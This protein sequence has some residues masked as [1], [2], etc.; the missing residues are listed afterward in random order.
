MS[1]ASHWCCG[2]QKILEQ[3]QTFSASPTI[4]LSGTCI[5]RKAINKDKPLSSGVLPSRQR[6]AICSIL[7]YTYSIRGLPHVRQNGL[8]LFIALARMVTFCKE[9]GGM[10]LVW[11]LRARS[12]KTRA[13][14][15]QQGHRPPSAPRGLFGFCFAPSER[16]KSSNGSRVQGFNSVQSVQS[17]VERKN[18]TALRAEY[19]VFYFAVCLIIVTLA[20]KLDYYEHYYWK[21]TRD[22]GAGKTLQ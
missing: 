3:A 2:C 9:G 8:F 21:K 11:A 20:A 15:W 18:C 4:T 16:L 19:T 5:H 22:R 12:Y 6:S 7:S 1:L 14:A 17:V 13:E 10:L